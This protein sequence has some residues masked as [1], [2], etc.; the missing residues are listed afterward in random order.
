MELEYALG[1]AVAPVLQTPSQFG[2]RFTKELLIVFAVSGSSQHFAE[3]LR[4][5]AYA[6]D[7]TLP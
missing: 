6:V 1:P 5:W 3:P 4:L 7:P 2:A